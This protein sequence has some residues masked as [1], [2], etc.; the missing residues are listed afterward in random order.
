MPTEPTE[1]TIFRVSNHHAPSCGRPPSVDGDAEGTYNG[2]FE[3]RYGE[4]TLFVYDRSKGEGFL[5][6]GDAGWEHAFRVVDGKPEG[7][8]LSPEERA[9]L[10]CC[11]MAARS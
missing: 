10:E 3:N 4:Q 11:W 6:C 5:H 8:V 1:P 9:W 2:Y 7:L